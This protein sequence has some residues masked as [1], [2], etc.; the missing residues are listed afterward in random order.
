MAGETRGTR[1]DQSSGYAGD[2]FLQ[3]AEDGRLRMNPDLADR[4]IADLE[5]TLAV[6]NARMRMIRVWRSASVDAE[7]TDAVMDAVFQE[8]TCPGQL[9]R[10]VIELPKYLEALRLARQVSP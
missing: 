9:E 8:Q 5:R 4:M 10:A 1:S 6:L 7:F 2:L 3:L